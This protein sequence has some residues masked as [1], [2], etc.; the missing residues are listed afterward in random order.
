MGARGFACGFRWDGDE[1]GSLGV[2]GDGGIV[3]WEERKGV[4]VIVREESMF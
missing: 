2:K 4:G 1:M 3:R